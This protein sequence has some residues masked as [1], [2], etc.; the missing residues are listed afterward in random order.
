MVLRAATKRKYLKPVSRARHAINSSKHKAFS[1]FTAEALA[2]G[3]PAIVSKE[4]AENLE[5]QAKPLTK[6]LVMVERAPIK[7]W[8]GVL[9][10]Y[11]EELYNVKEEAVKSKNDGK[12]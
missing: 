8:S 11:V 6:D 10:I 12:R 3:T 4:I 1:M 5:A 7:T 9:L 2:L